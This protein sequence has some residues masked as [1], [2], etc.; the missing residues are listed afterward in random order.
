MELQSLLFRTS[1]EGRTGVLGGLAAMLAIA[2]AVFRRISRRATEGPC[3]DA[4]LVG[5][6]ANCAMADTLGG[7]ATALNFG[8]IV[9]AGAAFGAAFLWWRHSAGAEHAR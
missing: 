8:A 6:E 4:D 2:A 3:A 1:W 7:I 9:V 5:M